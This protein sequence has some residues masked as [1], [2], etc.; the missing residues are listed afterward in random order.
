MAQHFL[1]SSA[2]RT[3]SLKTIYAEGEDA[4]YRRFCGLRWP[5][6]LGRPICPRCSSR[7][8]YDLATRRRFK[9]KAC[10]HQFSVTSG[11]IFA[12][13]KL[14]FVDLLGA[15]AVL[16][17]GAKG[18]SALQLSRCT[19]LS[20]KTAFVLAH[21]IREAL[22]I[23]TEGLVFDGTVE[24]DGAYGGGHVRPANARADRV[25]RRRKA[26][27]T[28]G[29]RSVV[30]LRQREGRTLTNVFQNEAEAVPVA[31]S[32]VVPGA[33][34][35]A[36]ETP[37]SDQLAE[38]FD[39]ERVNHSDAY[40][41]LDGIHVNGAENYF[42]RLRRMI[43]GQHHRVG[44]GRLGGY[45][46][47]PPGSRI[48]VETVME[49]WLPKRSAM[50]SPLS[51]AASGR[52]IGNAQRD[53]WAGRP[54]AHS[55]SLLDEDDEF[56]PRR[57]A[58]RLD[59]LE[60]DRV[61][62]CRVGRIEVTGSHHPLGQGASRQLSPIVQLLGAEIGDL[63]FSKE[64]VAH[65]VA[66]ALLLDIGEQ[67]Q[68]RVHVRQVVLGLFDLSLIRCDP[69]VDLRTL[70]PQSL[71]DQ[72]IFHAPHGSHDRA[73]RPAPSMVHLLHNAE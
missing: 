45:A 3:L 38:A 44:A 70:V 30:A 47:M 14:A 16:V 22:A 11:T 57:M 23:E 68:R 72:V 9:C 69:S 10:H 52:A 55:F 42:A 32:V 24:I 53:G 54:H 19:G 1:L 36:D 6:T 62:Q 8:A 4:A 49:P 71:D 15:I 18:V 43:R 12:S 58:K 51:S 33:T 26:H 31:K 41:F 35:V 5:E 13:R 63:A 27:R 73:D 20:Y 39:I 21:K 56:A 48:I 61:A 60:Y 2:A 29:R 46:A 64:T 67:A 17:N 7:E 28:E 59:N 34:L 37:H 65:H 66:G 50:A 40:S 25:D